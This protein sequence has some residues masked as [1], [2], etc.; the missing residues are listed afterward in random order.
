MGNTNAGKVG[1]GNEG[2]TDMNRGSNMKGTYSKS[3][4]KTGRVPGGGMT[5]MP[6]SDKDEDNKRSVGDPRLA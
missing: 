2:Q 1:S 3:S 5:S 6:N 4:R